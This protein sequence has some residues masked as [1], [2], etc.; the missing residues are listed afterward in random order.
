[1]GSLGNRVGVTSSCLCKKGEGAVLPLLVEVVKD[2]IDDSLDAGDVDEQYHG[3]GAAPDLT[4]VTVA[5]QM[6]HVRGK[7]TLRQGNRRVAEDAEK[8]AGTSRAAGERK[9]LRDG[10]P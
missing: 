6:S 5:R 8:E 10:L 7:R 9:G 4:D 1:M 2:G 3:A